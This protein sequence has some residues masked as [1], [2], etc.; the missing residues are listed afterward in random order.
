L[1]NTSAN[2]ADVED[3]QQLV[4]RPDHV[5]GIAMT[6]N[7]A[8]KEATRKAHRRRLV[9]MV[10]WCVINYLNFQIRLY[11]QLPMK[12][13]VTQQNISISNVLTLYIW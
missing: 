10:D 6:V 13:F 2:T 9:R 7:H 8:L 3:Q 4:L 11:G 5:S 12:S 1:N